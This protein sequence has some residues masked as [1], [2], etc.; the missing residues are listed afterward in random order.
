VVRA[1]GCVE[2]E[3]MGVAVKETSNVVV[4]V[5][6]KGSESEETGGVNASGEEEN[7][8]GMKRAVCG[9]DELVR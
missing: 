8:G 3:T 2:E 4:D 6:Y 7:V 9:T 5:S 1:F